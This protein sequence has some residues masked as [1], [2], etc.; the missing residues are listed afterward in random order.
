MR[1]G[2]RQVVHRH[3][4]NVLQQPMHVDRSDIQRLAG[5]EHVVHQ[6]RQTIAFADDDAGVLGQLRLF[7]FMGQQLRGAANAPQ[8]VLDLVGKAAHQAGRGLL[9]V[10]EP[11]VLIDALH[12]VEGLRLKQQIVAAVNGRTG[13]VNRQKCA[14][15]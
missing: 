4:G 13:Q 12:T 7:E 14:A 10:D 2:R 6:L 11:V 9:N 15:A 5:A 8:G 3:P 1:L